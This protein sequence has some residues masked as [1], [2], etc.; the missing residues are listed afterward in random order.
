MSLYQPVIFVA[1]PT[2][3]FIL[4]RLYTRRA[5]GLFAI[6]IWVS[7]ILY[8]RVGVTRHLENVAHDLVARSPAPDW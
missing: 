1:T 8:T 4:R 3:S 2:A 7:W 5:R 6:S